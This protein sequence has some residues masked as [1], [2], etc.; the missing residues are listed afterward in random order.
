M[1]AIERA[2]EFY[3]TPAD[4]YPDWD[5]LTEQEQDRLLAQYVAEGKITLCTFEF[6]AWRNF[7]SMFCDNEAD[8]D[9]ELCDLHADY[10]KDVRP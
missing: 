2:A 10:M 6:P 1:L 7:P 5:D 9:T 3:G 4:G 8:P